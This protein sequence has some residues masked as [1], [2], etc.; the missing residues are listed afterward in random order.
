V[1]ELAAIL[2]KKIEVRGSPKIA[3]REEGKETWRQPEGGECPQ[4]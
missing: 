4:Q 2:N 1:K 3:Q